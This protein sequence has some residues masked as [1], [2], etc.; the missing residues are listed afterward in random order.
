M[1]KENLRMQMLSGIITESEYKTKLN[2]EKKSSSLNEG[3]FKDSLKKWV[4]ASIAHIHKLDEKGRFQ[5]SDL[6]NLI[7]ILET[8]WWYVENG[9]EKYQK[10]LEQLLGYKLPKLNPPL[11]ENERDR[12]ESDRRHDGA[13]RERNRRESMTP[14][15]DWG[16]NI[17]G[18]IRNLLKLPSYQWVDGK[19]IT[20][21]GVES[22]EKTLSTHLD[23]KDSYPYNHAKGRGYYDWMQKVRER[24]LELKKSGK[25]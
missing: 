19:L 1:N 18:Y 3:D 4:E 5:F 9:G 10:R 24:Y 11:N 22:L 25:I 16:N 14:K 23:D 6:D 13:Q 20:L 15:D 21:T 2:K 17:D 12:L 8:A 7:D